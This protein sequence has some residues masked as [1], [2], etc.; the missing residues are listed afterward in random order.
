MSNPFRIPARNEFVREPM[1]TE[2]ERADMLGRVLRVC[3][4]LDDPDTIVIHLQRHG[5]AISQVGGILVTA[6][7]KA[8]AQ[9]RL[10]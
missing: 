1:L 5:I 2:A 8:R 6:L 7:D 9:R 10:A 3:P 4:D